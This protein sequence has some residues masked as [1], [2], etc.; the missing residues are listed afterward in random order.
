MAVDRK[1]DRR[2]G[3]P[4]PRRRGRGLHPAALRATYF[5]KPSASQELAYDPDKAAQL[6]DEAG[7]K[8]NGDGKRVGKDGKPINYRVLCHAT[9]P[10]DKAIGKYLKEWWGELGIGVT[11]DCLDNVTDPWLAGEYDLAFDGWSVNPDPDFVLSIHTCARAPGDAQGHRRDRQLHLRQEV[12]RAV[13]RS[14][15]PSTTPP[16]GRT[17]SS[18]CSRGCTTPGT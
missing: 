15:S 9:D 13:R 1:T 8:K 4:G 16:N 5:W 18:R 3:L 12:R 17:S 7:Y 10:N 6:L 14:S 2:Q 11:L